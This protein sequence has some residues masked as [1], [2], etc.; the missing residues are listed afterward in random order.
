MAKLIG[1]NKISLLNIEEM[2][3]EIYTPYTTPHYRDYKDQKNNIDSLISYI[4]NERFKEFINKLKN[5]SINF[6][7]TDVLTHKIDLSNVIYPYKYLSRGAYGATFLAKFKKEKNKKKKGDDD[8]FVVKYEIVRDRDYEHCQDEYI[9]CIDNNKNNEQRCKV[10]EIYCRLD[11][12]FIEIYINKNYIQKL[13]S[14]N[15][16]MFY[17]FFMCPTFKILFDK[18]GKYPTDEFL[19]K[20]IE[21]K[22]FCVQCKDSNVEAEKMHVFSVYEYIPGKTL[23]KYIQSNSFSIKTLYKIFLQ[24]FGALSTAQIPNKIYYNHND[25]HCNNIMVQNYQKSQ[26]YTYFLPYQKTKNS[27]SSNKRAV[28]IDQGNASLICKQKDINNINNTNNIQY[29]GVYGWYKK[30]IT[31]VIKNYNSPYADV[32]R[33]ITDSYSRMLDCNKSREILKKLKDIIND[34]FSLDGMPPS[35]RGLFDFFKSNMSNIEL[36]TVCSDF[37]ENE[38]ELWFDRY[39]IYLE[40]NLSSENF[41]IL[42]KK[43]EN[44]TYEFAFNYFNNFRI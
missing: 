5:T 9:D 19:N 28:I 41:S 34:L 16:A 30:S 12:A 31:K 11:S 32:F 17:A 23:A 39:V 44:I 36:S 27:V 37:I 33:V 40:K 8:Y 15:F 14:R 21:N 38:Q 18:S 1:K 22:Q 20:F 43:I 10:K 25:L 13:N 24:L 2:V 42:M 26:K 3:R 7:N 6:K 4:K 29:T 35:T